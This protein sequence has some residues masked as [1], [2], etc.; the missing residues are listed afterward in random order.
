ME[1]LFHGGNGEAVTFDSTSAHEQGFSE[2]GIL[3]AQELADY[4]NTLVSALSTDESIRLKPSGTDLAVDPQG[5]PLAAAYFEAAKQFAFEDWASAPD[6]DNG[7]V[8]KPQSIP[9]SMSAMC[10]CG[11]WSTPR[12]S[13]AAPWVEF[14]SSDPAYI[15]QSWGFRQTPDYAGG[16][17]TR[18]QTYS[19]WICGFNTYRDHAYITGNTLHLQD[20]AGFTPRGEPNPEVWASGPWPYPLW[21][22]YVQW[23]HQNF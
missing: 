8:V 5:L 19:P 1:P 15:L 12:P 21:P 9:C 7:E 17:W 6:K 10:T 3:L 18:P 23:W 2:K 13:S 4:T 16:G 22:S 14:W 20:Y 11:S